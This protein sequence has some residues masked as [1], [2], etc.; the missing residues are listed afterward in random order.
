VH[1]AYNAGAVRLS[2]QQLKA[3]SGVA[4]ALSR[5][6]SFEEFPL[7]AIRAVEHF[8]PSDFCGFNE[9]EKIDGAAL[10][11]RIVVYPDFRG[12]LLAFQQYIRQHPLFPVVIAGTVKRSVKISDF[13]RLS[14]WCQT[15]LYNN[16]YRSENQNYQLVFVCQYPKLK[17]G[18]SFNRANTDFTEEERQMADLI[19]V[20]LAQAHLNSRI[21]SNI[22]KGQRESNDWLLIANTAGKI[23]F[24]TGPTKQC[25]EQHIGPITNEML[26]DNVRDWLRCRSERLGNAELDQP[27]ELRLQSENGGVIIRFIAR[28][29]SVETY[30]SVQAD[31]LEKTACDL[32]KLGLTKRES[33][34]LYWVTQGKRNG[35]IGVILGT[36]PKTITKHVEK[37]FQKLSVETRSAA[38]GIALGYLNGSTHGISP[39][40]D[41][42]LEDRLT[43]R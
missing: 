29:S 13:S 31:P 7:H 30:L 6:T 33:E 9:F 5:P 8:L 22:S 42:N 41:K 18:L 2:H 28:N 27:N 23:R 26:P 17:V 20:H 16:F 43:G 32:Q 1:F 19:R 14:R 10:P 21:L 35:E 12:N 39:L 11:K 4:L 3:F 15:D 38:A 37:I 40:Q 24:M 34:V 36:K 25:L